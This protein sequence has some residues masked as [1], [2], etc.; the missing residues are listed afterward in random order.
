M[1]IRR[2]FLQQSSVLAAAVM[3]QETGLLKPHKDLG[4]QL[5]TVRDE[6]SSYITKHAITL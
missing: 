6:T 3:I 4:I 2:S 5:Y 1:L